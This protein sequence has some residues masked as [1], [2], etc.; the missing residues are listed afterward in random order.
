MKVVIDTNVI[1]SALFFEGIPLEILKGAIQKK[2]TPVVSSNIVEE[3]YQTINKL[4]ERFPNVEAHIQL[5]LFLS[6]FEFCQTLK[7]KVLQ[8]QRSFF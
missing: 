5:Q 8:Q 4:A 1:A 3:Y 2:F 7:R 6:V